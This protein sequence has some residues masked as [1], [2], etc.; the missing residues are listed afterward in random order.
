MKPETVKLL[1][2]IKVNL[3]MGKLACNYIVISFIRFNSLKTLQVYNTATVSQDNEQ[4][5]KAHTD[6][7]NFT[8]KQ[9]FFNSKQ[10][11][12]VSFRSIQKK[13]LRNLQTQCLFLLLEMTK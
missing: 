6:I 7:N 4:D 11:C 1:L 12:S 3:S 13:V 2:F 8:F 10:K 9:Y 5:S